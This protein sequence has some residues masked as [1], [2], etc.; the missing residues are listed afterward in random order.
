M[1]DPARFFEQ[2]GYQV[3]VHQDDDEEW[4]VDLIP[5]T[6]PESV[7][8]RY[9]RGDTKPDSA[10]RAMERWRVEQIGSG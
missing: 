9:G 10:L 4:W 1:T 5:T 6:N 8:F 3:S 7:I 2:L